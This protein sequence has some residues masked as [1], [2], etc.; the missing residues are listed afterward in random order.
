MTC[1]WTETDE[2]QAADFGACKTGNGGWPFPDGV[3][4]R[5]EWV[6]DRGSIGP[7][8]NWRVGAGATRRR[9]PLKQHWCE[10]VRLIF[11]SIRFG[12]HHSWL[13]N[14]DRIV[15]SYSKHWIHMN[16]YEFM[17][18]FRFFLLCLHVSSQFVALG[19]R[20]S[21]SPCTARW[22]GLML[23]PSPETSLLQTSPLSLETIES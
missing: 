15:S 11:T 3:P 7:K 4:W 1:F 17:L 21:L 10:M 12:G 20:S 9:I 23:K 14:C 19:F 13:Q 18:F 16:S 5:G 8:S 22:Q 2:S 6:V